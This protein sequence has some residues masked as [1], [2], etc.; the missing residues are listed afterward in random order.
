MLL[1]RPL[2]SPSTTYA[3]TPARTASRIISPPLSVANITMG[4]GLDWLTIT[5][6]SSTS[7]VGDSVSMT[8]TSGSNVSTARRSSSGEDSEA[9]TSWPAEVSASRSNSAR[10]SDSST[11]RTRMDRLQNAAQ[12]HDQQHDQ[13][14]AAEFVYPVFDGKAVAGH[15]RLIHAP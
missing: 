6:C 9:A 12:R 1:T 10:S 15:S 3:E 14:Y 11:I 7:R 8:M 13:H 5:T 4:R 2:S